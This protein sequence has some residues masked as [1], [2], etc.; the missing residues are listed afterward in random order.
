V[1]VRRFHAPGAGDD[2]GHR[3]PRRDRRPRWCAQGLPR[4][5]GRGGRHRERGDE[6]LRAARTPDR[7]RALA[8]DRRG[9]TPTVQADLRVVPESSWGAALMYFTGSKD[10]NVRLRE[11]AIKR[12]MTLNEYGLFPETRRKR[13]AR[14]RSAASNPSRARPRRRS[15]RRSRC[16]TPARDAGGPGGARRTETPELVGRGD[17]GRAARAHDRVGRVA[18]ARGAHFGRTG[19]RLP[20]DHGDRSLAEQRAGERAER[21]AARS[22]ARGDREAQRRTRR[23]SRSCTGARWTSSP[24]GRSTTTTRR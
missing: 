8:R 2:R 21:R 17:P 9:R 14:P 19:A 6:D 23:S 22:A 5:A 10:H 4:A 1:R 12:G 18:R 15:T 7:L 11:R 20:H 3:H 24:T 13:R 16:R